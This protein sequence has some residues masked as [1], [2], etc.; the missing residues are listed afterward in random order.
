MST[1][2][3]IGIL[4]KN[5]NI[6]SIYCH[7]DGYPE[8]NGVLL[9]KFYNSPQK[10]NELLDLGDISSLKQNVNPVSQNHTFETP[11]KNVTIAYHRDR[12]EQNVSART[13]TN[14]K[15]YEYKILNNWYDF[16]YIFNENTNK[17]LVLNIGEYLYGDTLKETNFLDNYKDL[18]KTLE[19]LQKNGQ[20][21]FEFE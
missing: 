2:S 5:G 7:H 13:D 12:G 4:Q 19:E 20:E 14:I 1:R 6:R 3:N 9:K 10:I 17:W 18:E 16:A 11:D 15:D 21:L 8:Y